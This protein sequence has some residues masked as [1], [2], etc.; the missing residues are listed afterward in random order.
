MEIILT[1]AVIL[2]IIIFFM[3]VSKSGAK[4]LKER[5]EKINRA[6]SAKA[7]ILGCST[8]SVRGTGTHGR[9]QSYNFSLEVWNNYKAPYKAEVV[10]EVY[11]MGAPKVQ[12]GAEIDVKIDADD[13]AVIYPSV[14]FIEFSWLGTMISGKKNK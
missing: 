4:M 8:G 13:P 10:W 5:Q 2:A 7:K 9:Y 12:E 6:E 3:Y 11:D 1:I 14:K